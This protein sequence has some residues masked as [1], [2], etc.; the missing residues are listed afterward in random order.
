M[1]GFPLS[2][3]QIKGMDDQLYEELKRLASKEKRS[4]SQQ[5]VF[6]FR[7]YLARRQPMRA[8]K[9][10]AQVLLELAGSWQDAEDAKTVIARIKKAR[11]KSRKLQKGL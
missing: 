7:D 9:T 2:N 6:L 10:P 3:F 1:E 4:V 5:A 8:A 11:R